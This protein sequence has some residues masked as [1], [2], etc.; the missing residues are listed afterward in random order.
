[1]GD[2]CS[3]V[4]GGDDVQPQ[5]FIKTEIDT[6]RAVYHFQITVLHRFPAGAPLLPMIL[7]VPV[8]S[9]ILMAF[10]VPRWKSDTLAI[11]VKVIN[12]SG[13]WNSFSMLV[14]CPHGQY[15]M[16]MGIV[17]R[18]VGVMYG[19]INNHALGNK[20]LLAVVL[21]HL[22]IQFPWHF[23]GQSQHKASGNLG[24]PLFF[25]GFGSM[26]SVWTISILWE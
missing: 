14:H 11:L 16:T 25:Y 20:K 5:F 23:F 6:D 12:L 21:H 8:N 22:R 19:K 1:M 10:P 9:V 3:N 26:I 17:S 13:F 18:W 24:V 2:R 4:D 15:H 7:L